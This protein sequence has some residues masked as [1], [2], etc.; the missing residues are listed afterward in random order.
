[1]PAVKHSRAVFFQEIAK[2]VPD[3]GSI[4]HVPARFLKELNLFLG[5]SGEEVATLFGVSRPAIVRK[6]KTATDEA[7]PQAPV[8]AADQT[9]DI[10]IPDEFCDMPTEEKIQY[11][12]RKY[13]R[14]IDGKEILSK[15]QIAALK[16]R[17]E[18]LRTLQAEETEE[19]NRLVRQV[20]NV[21]LKDYV[22]NFKAAY[23]AAFLTLKTEMVKASVDTT[24]SALDR[25]LEGREDSD[26][27]KD[28]V[29]NKLQIAVAGLGREF[30][31]VLVF[32]ETG[33]NQPVLMQQVEKYL[34]T[35]KTSPGLVGRGVIADPSSVQGG[36]QARSKQREQDREE[37]ARKGGL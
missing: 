9:A 31:P 24:W 28:A 27:L 30:D 12:T 17:L 5:F 35:Q 19:G 36:A 37:A 21:L 6:A 2:Q 4:A 15:D 26:K 8:T 3:R 25:I 32:L 1:M 10:D 18:D 33:K 7:A 29:L 20:L 11:I 16:N 23:E 34:A 14:C 22:R 13:D